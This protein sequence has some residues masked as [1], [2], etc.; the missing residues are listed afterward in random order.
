M[1]SS[2]LVGIIVLSFAVGTTLTGAV[3]M[4]TEDR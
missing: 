2:V 3:F 1:T 4:V